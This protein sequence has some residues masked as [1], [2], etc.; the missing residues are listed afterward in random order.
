MK[1]VN[2]N[3]IIASN[4]HGQY[5]YRSFSR[6]CKTVGI[7]RR[8]FRTIPEKVETP[9]G[10]FTIQKL[11]MNVSMDCH[12]FRKFICEKFKVVSTGNDHQLIGK[13]GDQYTVN[14]DTFK[15]QIGW[16]KFFQQEIKLDDSTAEFVLLKLKESARKQ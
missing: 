3:I 1:I 14:T 9:F 2:E 10:Q 5:P 13:S 4:E 6:F 11:P 7:T 16:C 15:T 8:D 12:R